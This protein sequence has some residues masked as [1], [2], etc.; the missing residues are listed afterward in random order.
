MNRPSIYIAVLLIAASFT[1]AQPVGLQ[2]IEAPPDPA[3][4]SL[5][6]GGV[7]GT[8]AP[9]SWYS[10]LGKAT[11]RNVQHATLTPVLPNAAV[12]TGTAVIVLPGG[13]F[14]SLSME[15]EGWDVARWLAD[16]GIA[17]FVLKYR[18]RPM[19]AD[20]KAYTEELRKLFSAKN[21]DDPKAL[22]AP[23]DALADGEAAL[24]MVRMRAKDWGIDS[25]KIGML[26]FSAGAITTLSVTL[27]A[28]PDAMPA[29]V[30]PIYGP[31]SAV[32]V[33]AS[34]PPMFIALAS[35]DPL[36]AKRGFGLVDSWVTAKRPIELHFYQK[37]G[38][39]FGLGK[40][41]TTSTDWPESFLRWL[42]LN[43]FAKNRP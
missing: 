19:P 12:A 25:T 16:H 33:P 38:H 39:G 30:A 15:S 29:F 41:G 32:T 24:R 5:G 40:P 26:G 9:E 14:V 4:I 18:L 36:F 35:D 34:A 23:A 28:T 7:E 22:Q 17:A 10:F 43:G 13:G 2:G 20:W 11:A 37:G 1:Q 6:T 27:N 21:L 8:L 42:Q 3:A 31:M